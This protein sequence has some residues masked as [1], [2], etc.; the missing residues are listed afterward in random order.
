MLSVDQIARRVKHQVKT[1]N[2][3]FNGLTTNTIVLYIS[4]VQ[5]NIGFYA[6]M[7]HQK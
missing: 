4:Y 7:R 1:M 3:L 2:Y 5:N 6:R